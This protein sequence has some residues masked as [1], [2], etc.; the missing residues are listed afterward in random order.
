MRLHIKTI[1]KSI[2]II[3]CFC[4]ISHAVT[5]IDDDFDGPAGTVPDPAIWIVTPPQWGDNP[6][7]D[8]VLLD[9]QSY[10]EADGSG[11]QNLMSIAGT[12]GLVP[13]EAEFCRVTY[14]NLSQSPTNQIN[15]GVN[16]AQQFG[17]PRIQVRADVGGGFYSIDITDGN[18]CWWATDIPTSASGTWAIEWYTN[19]IR[20]YFDGIL[21][22]DS[23]VN[24][25]PTSG[26]PSW[27][28]P[29]SLLHPEIGGGYGM[30]AENGYFKVDRI[31]W[32]SLPDPDYDPNA[33]EPPVT[34]QEQN[35]F[36]VADINKDCYVNLADFT[37]FAVD[38]LKCND[39]ENGDCTESPQ[40]PPFEEMIKLPVNFDESM[41]NTPVL[42]NG[43]TLLVQ[44]FRPVPPATG[45]NYLFIEDIATGWEVARFGLD[46]SFVSAYVN[47]NQMNVFASNGD[48]NRFVSTNLQTWSQTLAIP[49]DGSEYLYN[50]SVCKDGQGYLMAYESN[51]PVGF[52]FKFARS[53]DLATWTKING[54]VFTGQGN[55]YSACPVIRYIEPYY[56]VIYLH[57]AI[58]DHN[59]WI[60]FA[61]RSLDLVTW[62][63]SPKNPILEA[64]QGEGMNNSDVD[65]F[66]WEGKTYIYYATGD[67]A[68]WIALRTAMYPGTM[69]QFFLS[70]FPEG[71]PMIEITT[72][73]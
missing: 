40:P 25:V 36:A 42:F 5:A 3:S 41:E 56:Y 44:N 55:E 69:R 52:C 31:I 2:V 23:T 24:T 1:S 61:A 72:Q 48:I 6:A 32:E 16:G 58:P 13:S 63:L 37:V 30:T 59:G 9:G 64:G 70:C 18:F 21:K 73:R 15:F 66:E 38:W 60:S 17:Q 10:V 22:F 34:C 33:P 51:Q 71:E 62:Q 27:T 4:S 47:G 45:Q 54:L 8:A 29:S 49:R 28:I 68:T 53:T 67:Q 43:V 65:L 57:A 14:K 19:K 26:D 12:Y 39:P 35:E 46:H 11:F 7:P 50:S 20:V